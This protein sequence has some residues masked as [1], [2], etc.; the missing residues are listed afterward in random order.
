MMTIAKS[1]ATVEADQRREIAEEIFKI[2]LQKRELV[3]IPNNDWTQ[4]VRLA[5][6]REVASRFGVDFKV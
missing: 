5:E 1:L 3:L 2:V 6:L 4:A